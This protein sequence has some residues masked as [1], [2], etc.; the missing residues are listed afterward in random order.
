LGDNF[1]ADAKKFDKTK[2]VL[3]IVKVETEA[4]ATTEKLNE[5]G[6]KNIYELDG[7]FMKWSDEGLNNAKE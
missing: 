5:L 6:F 4:K 2:P 7:G 1:V 3:Y